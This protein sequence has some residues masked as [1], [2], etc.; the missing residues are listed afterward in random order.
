[1]SEKKELPTTLVTGGNGFVGASVI[2]ALLSTSHNH[3][4][5]L[6]VRNTSSA[7]ALVAAHPEWPNDH[8]TIHAVPDFTVPGAFD[9]VFREHDDIEYVVHVAAPLLDDPRNTDFVEHF[10]KPSV[11][12]NVG[13]LTSAK[14]YGKNVKA[15]SVT[16]SI[17]AITLGDQ[18]DVK[19][20]VFGN[21]EWLSL[22]REDAIKAQHNYISY[23]VGK[24]LAEKALWQFVQDEHPS[25]TVTNF[26]PPL[27]FG[28]MEQNVT[29]VDKVNFSNSQI[30]AIMNSATSSDDK[31]VPTTM[32][33]AYIDVRDLAE[34]QIQALTNPKAANRRFIVGFPM[35][36]ND[37]ADALRANIP[38][39]KGRVGE[40]NDDSET[41]TPVRID[42]HDA[43]SVFDIKFRTLQE[44]AVD[45]AARILK[46]E[47]AATR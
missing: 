7:E 19:K 42:T 37:F 14:Q 3:K 36:F 46:L 6:A 45:T 16:G 47:A 11:L 2:S 41:L 17:N 23:C 31:K 13:L 34:L 35:F 38:E 44:T 20:R 5:I 4:V 27:I 29:S 15:V 22:D 10:E 21:D 32:F 8:I 28:P 43:D 24:K 33:P 18:D 30:L 26:M 9:S 40:N 12:G 1:M 25:F 39:L